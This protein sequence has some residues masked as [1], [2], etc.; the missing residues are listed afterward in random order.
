MRIANDSAT[1]LA[2][3][4]KHHGPSGQEWRARRRDANS[5]PPCPAMII[6][7]EFSG[8][9]STLTLSTTNGGGLL[10]E[11]RPFEP[12]SVRSKPL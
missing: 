4:G 6:H 2:V 11:N 1:R 5:K 3:G 9:I 10:V 7:V 8:T 12:K